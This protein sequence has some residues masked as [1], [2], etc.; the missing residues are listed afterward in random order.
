MKIFLIVALLASVSFAQKAR[1][2]AGSID[3]KSSP[4]GSKVV[5]TASDDFTVVTKKET[6]A[7]VKSECGTGWV[8]V[9]KIEYIKKGGD[10]AME[11]EN[12]DIV[13][14]IDNPS[15]VFVLE[16]NTDEVE[17]VNLERNFKEYLK[18]TMDKEQIE[19]KNQDN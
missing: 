15:A 1:A 4:G 10:K 7:Q 18:N 11:F 12:V 6:H 8:E 19:M 16:N 2:K 9:S 5:C 17:G 3:L 13:G 14:W